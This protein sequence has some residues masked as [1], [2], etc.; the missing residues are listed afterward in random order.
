MKFKANELLDLEFRDN[1]QETPEERQDREIAKQEHIAELNSVANVYTK[2]DRILVGDEITCHV[3]ENEQYKEAMPTGAWSDGKNIY[4]NSDLIDE[5]DEA[6]LV[7]LHGL[8]YHEVAHILYSPRSSSDITKW[9]KENQYG[10]SFNI[11]EEARIETL[12]TTKY[13]STRIFLEATT[14]QYLLDRPKDEWADTYPIMVGRKYVD[15]EWREITG[16]L[17][18]NKYGM[19]LAVEITDI[20]NKYRTLVFPDDYDIAKKLI[21]RLGQIING[22]INLPETKTCVNRQGM[23]KGR[24]E[25]K[26]EQEKLQNRAKGEKIDDPQLKGE[27]VKDDSID[28]LNPNNPID[29]QDINAGLSDTEKEVLKQKLESLLNS[30]VVKDELRNTQKALNNGAHR[31]SLPKAGLITNTTPTTEMRGIAKRFADELERLRVEADPSW[32]K[33]T[34]SGRLNIGRAMNRDINKLDSVFDRWEFNEDNSDIEAVILLDRSGSMSNMA[35]VCQSAWAIKRAIE[36]INGKVAIYSFNHNSRTLYRTDEKA[37]PNVFRTVWGN[38][39][40]DPYYGL[41]E[42][43]R[44]FNASSMPTKLLFIL[45]DGEWAN[46]EACDN[47]I[48]RLNQNGVE[49]SVVYIGRLDIAMDYDNWVEWQTRWVDKDTNADEVA[50]LI[51]QTKYDEYKSQYSINRYKHN[52]KHF[53][54]IAKPTDLVQ[55]A[56]DITR[57]KIKV[58]R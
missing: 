22:N 8:N 29:N 57:T 11:L 6:S 4:F 41:L 53:R 54:V 18:A 50:E 47:T 23:D 24:P 44:A 30:K 21:E 26:R 33:E 15:V 39:G 43:E 3:V 49:T 37:N 25:G 56:R 9:A 14:L 51:N 1:W 20:V 27:A 52:A 48:K 32:E 58:A 19:A 17:F 34:P 36:R 31:N 45:T 38:G 7:S 16:N 10:K 13:P 55:V 12:L 46:E 28:E 35:N 42:A 2:A 40:T 5:V